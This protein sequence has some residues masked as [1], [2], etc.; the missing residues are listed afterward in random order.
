M[1][2]TV[3]EGKGVVI[4]YTG[5][6]TSGEMSN[7]A[8]R[9]QASAKFDNI[10]Y[11]IHDFTECESLSVSS[12]ELTTMVARASVA[13]EKRKVFAAAFV[14]KIPALVDAF[15][16]IKS[17][18]AYERDMQIFTSLPDARSFIAR[19]TNIGRRTIGSTNS[20]EEQNENE[21]NQE[22]VGSG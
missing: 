6:V 19:V 10:Q 12:F 3:W 4:R 17:V 16:H 7:A 8:E 18:G 13:V 15:M 14:G 1:Q 5:V 11:V 9:V 21:V 20:C 22:S 2:E